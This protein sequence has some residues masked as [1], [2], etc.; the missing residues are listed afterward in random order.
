[1]ELLAIGPPGLDA[2]GYGE[3]QRRILLALEDLGWK[4]T[5]RPFRSLNTLIKDP[6]NE[7][8]LKNMEK[9]PLPP[10]GSVQIFFCPAHM[11][12]A[13]SKYYNVGFTMTEADKVDKKWV[14]KCNSMDEVWIPSRFN[15]ETFLTCGVRKEKLHIMHL[16][17]DTN[18][19]KPA[20]S[21][22]SKKKVTFISSFELIPRKGCDVLLEAFSEE[23]DCLEPVELVIKAY[24]NGGRY[25]P[26]GKTLSNLLQSVFK[27]YPKGG[28][29]RLKKEIIPYS[30]LP[31][32]YQKATC[33]V[34]ASRGE[35]WNLPAME[36]MACG[37]PVIALRWSGH[38]EFLNS[39][40]SF[41]VEVLGLEEIKDYWCPGARWAIVDKKALRQKM[42]Y[43][44]EN[45]YD[46]KRKGFEAR[47]YVE[48]KYSIEKIA[49]KISKRL[50]NR[51]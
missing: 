23:F 50:L 29:I 10:P 36:A 24:E 17:V 37:V 2:S 41:L 3:M 13:N 32:L 51:K 48:Q 15:Y 38:T 46:V 30:D 12:E 14:E 9:N 11:F 43:V 20:K 42:R 27:K 34:S 21:T 26:Q 1:M 45:R 19:F 6:I 22:N 47:K 49:F 44:A 4:V 31:E 5:L 25:D 39:R 40:N 8:R 7:S 35:G 28:A 16:G 18:H 33:Y